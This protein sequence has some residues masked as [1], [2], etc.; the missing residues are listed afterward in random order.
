MTRA[1]TLQQFKLPCGMHGDPKQYSKAE[2]RTA[3]AAAADRHNT[4]KRLSTQH[5][6]FMSFAV[7]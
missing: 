2:L 1:S 7:Y 3:F 4:Q 6:L 5:L